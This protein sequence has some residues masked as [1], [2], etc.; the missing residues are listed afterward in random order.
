MA[1][2]WKAAA[3]AVVTFS[4]L[5]LIGISTRKDGARFALE[6]N[7]DLSRMFDK[8]TSD[9]DVHP[10]K[11][12]GKLLD[13]VQH[14]GDL[15]DL[16]LNPHK[17]VDAVVSAAAQVGIKIKHTATTADEQARAAAAVE[18]LMQSAEGKIKVRHKKRYHLFRF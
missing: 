4:L 18:A 10:L 14:L 13:E 7:D 2:A 16:S 15:P 12:E 6:Q 11:G 17:K 3:L 9:P 5:A 8:E 1:R